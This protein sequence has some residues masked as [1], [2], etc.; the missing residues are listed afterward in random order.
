MKL[1]TTT[2]FIFGSLMALTATLPAQAL[3]FNIN[4]AGGNIAAQDSVTSAPGV[5]DFTFNFSG[6][7]Y[8]TNNVT[9]SIGSLV[10]GGTDDLSQLELFLSSPAGANQKTLTLSSFSLLGT[11][12]TSTVFSD[13]GSS[14]GSGSAPYTGTFQPA[15]G[16]GS[17]FN[18]SGT[19]TSFSE[20]FAGIDP[21]G[22]WT[23]SIY[24]D[25]VNVSALGNVTLTVQADVPFDFDSTI[26]LLVLG[27]FW[28]MRKWSKLMNRPVAKVKI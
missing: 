6:T 26:G 19:F 4:N 5:S 17:Y 25:N 13:A 10:T 27:G 15:G 23:L 20:A 18:G 2:G 21:V 24:S 12:M 22:D 3:D 14:I 8:T 28:G 11:Q 16:F 9:L 1:L 7:G